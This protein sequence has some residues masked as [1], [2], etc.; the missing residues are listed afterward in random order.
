V[1]VPRFDL[2]QRFAAA[3]D[4]GNDVLGGDFQMNGVGLLFQCSA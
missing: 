4:V 1:V 3:F 2:V